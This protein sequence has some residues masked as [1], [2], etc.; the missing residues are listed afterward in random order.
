MKVVVV[1]GSQGGTQMCLGRDLG[2]DGPRL[3]G[4]LPRQRREE[5]ADQCGSARVNGCQ[6][7]E[8]DQSV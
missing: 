1:L 3:P 6:A 4:D 2:G 7:E 5:Q 8:Q